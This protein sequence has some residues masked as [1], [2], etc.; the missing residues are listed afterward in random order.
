[1]TVSW[2]RIAPFVLAAV[3]T[4]PVT[5]VTALAQS[6]GVGVGAPATPF[7]LRTLEGTPIVLSDFRGRPLVINFFAS[8]CDPCRDEM[9]LIN[10]LATRGRANGYAVLGIAVE[11][12]QAAVEQFARAAKIDFPVALDTNSRVKRAFRI[13]GPPATFFIDG[14][15]TIRDIVMGPLTA[16]RAGAALRNAGAA[17]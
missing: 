7:Q 14:S 8:W 4:M 3:V 2:R 10:E 6:Q 16:E 17:R 15:G 9:P 5:A 12:R 13:F 1:M 11:D